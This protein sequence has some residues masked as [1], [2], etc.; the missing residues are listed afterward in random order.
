MPFKHWDLVEYIPHENAV[1]KRI[2]SIGVIKDIDPEG[3]LNVQ[4]LFPMWTDQDKQGEVIG[5]FTP[6]VWRRIGHIPKR[7]RE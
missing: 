5:W 1:P 7:H 6:L 3:Q 4:M 2:G